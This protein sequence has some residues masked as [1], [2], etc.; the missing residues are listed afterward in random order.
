MEILELLLIQNWA[1]PF[2]PEISSQA[3][4]ALERG[5]ILL[6]PTLSFDLLPA[7][8]R[9]AVTAALAAVMLPRDQDNGLFAL[10]QVLQAANE[11]YMTPHEGRFDPQVIHKAYSSLHPLD[12]TPQSDTSTATDSPLV[13]A[14]SRCTCEVVDTG[15]GRHYFNLK[16]PGVTTLMLSGLVRN[17][18]A[19]GIDPRR[20]ESIL[21]DG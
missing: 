14:N 9:L 8:Q 18:Y 6:A 3:V 12:L 1:G 4:T 15:L 17:A 5:K 11:A 20:L 19:L 16:V 10:R 13:I 21:I 2:S 7:E